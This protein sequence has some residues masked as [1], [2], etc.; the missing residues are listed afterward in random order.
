MSYLSEMLGESYKEGMT[1]EE[2]SA[3][4]E[5]RQQNNDSEIGRLRNALNKANSEA[6]EYKKKIRETQTEEEQ[7]AAAQKEEYDRIIQENA[8]LKRSM[9]I[10]TR[11]AQLIAQGYEEKLADETATAMIDGDLDKVLTNQGI[12]LEAQ[13]KAIKEGQMRTTP[14]PSADGNDGD[15]GSGVDWDKKISEAN[16]K[17]LIAE[18][19]YY[20]RL[21]AMEES[22]QL[23]QPG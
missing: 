18:A 11:K 20:T 22:A 17:G 16:E 19:A 7:K 8:D 5:K 10:S 4:L 9:N 23:Q 15:G 3:A 13:T 21:K 2:I 6:A 1:E 12:F 14:R